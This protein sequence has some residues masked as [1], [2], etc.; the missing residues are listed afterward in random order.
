MAAERR[1]RTKSSGNEGGTDT[2]PLHGGMNEIDREEGASGSHRRAD[3]D[4]ETAPE[5]PGYAGQE[6]ERETPARKDPPS[7]YHDVQVSEGGLTTRTMPSEGTPPS[8]S[9]GELE[10]T[11]GQKIP[12]ERGEFENEAANAPRRDPTD[13]G[14]E[15]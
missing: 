14:D 13:R 9:K 12:Q 1:S 8:P 10:A 6:N 11:A 3:R 5:R 15:P 7:P 4:R 2:E